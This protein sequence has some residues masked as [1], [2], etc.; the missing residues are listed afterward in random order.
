MREQVRDPR[1]REPYNRDP[2]ALEAQRI[3]NRQAA[4]SQQRTARPA[5]PTAH[6]SEPSNRPAAQ[7]NT[8]RR[9]GERS[10]TPMSTAD[11]YRNA[12]RYAKRDR[13]PSFN[14][15]IPVILAAIAIVAGV[16]IFTWV[17]S[18]PVT[19]TVNGTKMEVGGEKTATYIYNQGA[20]QVKPGNLIDVEGQVLQEGKGNLFTLTVNDQTGADPD[21]RLSNGDVLEFTDGD[22]V[23]E[24]S[25]VNESQV[26][27][28]ET[29][30]AGT[31]PIHAVIQEGADGESTT[32]TGSI[33]GKTV[34]QVTKPAQ[35]KVYRRYFPDTQGEKVI[36]LTFDDGP[37]AAQTNELLDVLKE[38]G[39]KATFFTIGQQIEGENIDVVKRAAKEG[40]Q[41]CTHTFDHAAGSGQGVN[42][43]FMS[44][45]EQL[46]EVTKGMQAIA[47][48]TGADASTVIRA[49]GGNFPLAVWQN[50]ESAV[51]AEIGW[52]IDTEDWRQPGTDAIIEAVESAQPG[53]II[54]MHDGGGD[55][56]QTIAACR[57]ALPYLASKGYKFI[58]IDEMMKYPVANDGAM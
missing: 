5:D 15:K 32:K 12:D 18:L 10:Y 17:Q 2:H 8:A 57:E 50:V 16:G 54:L 55:R 26:L 41:I 28:F 4:G 53:S 56:S 35:N 47:S 27:P 51:T 43:S 38:N 58:T 45:Q 36:A 3:R 25:T 6:G 19:V 11:S 22:D 31:G 24:A 9:R 46:D 1:I 29:V 34:T 44:P 33:S 20:V 40:H 37:V 52:N 7:T 30:E 42:L 13:T 21:K 48:A 14:F 49:P 23:E 39:A